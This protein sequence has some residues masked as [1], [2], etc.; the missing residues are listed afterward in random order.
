MREE[1]SRLS[2]SPD[3]QDLDQKPAAGLCDADLLNALMEHLPDNIYFKD[4]SSRFIRINK[5]AAKWFG[6]NHPDDAI[7]KTDF[8]L[9]TQEHAQQAFNDEQ[10]IIRTGK[11][12]LHREEKETWPDGTVTWVDTSKLPLRDRNGNVI[13]TFGI[14]TDITEKKRAEESLRAAKEAAEVAREAAESASRAKSEFVA[15]M[16]HEIRTPMNAIIGMAE[17]LLDTSLSSAQRDYSQTILESGESLLGLLNDVLDFA[18]IE[19]G[20]VELDPMPF[21]IRERIGATMKT[22]AA[23]AHRK[24]LELACRIEA[25]VPE[26]VIGDFGRIRQILLNLIGNA[27]K[28]TDRGE[29]VLE[30]SVVNRTENQA[31]L[32]FDIRDTG[33]GIPP[34]KIGSIFEEFEQ[35]DKSTTRRFGGTGLGLTIA[36]RLVAL[37]GGTIAV[38]SELGSGSTF[39][40]TIPL[41]ISESDAAVARYAGPPS[42]HGLRV[43][44]VDDNATNRR[45]LTETICGWGMHP[46]AV[47]CAS[48]ALNSL[49]RAYQGG[50]PFGLVLSDL[51]M[52]EM[53]GFDLAAAVR[54]QDRFRDL[55]ILIL[56][57]GGYPDDGAR[58]RALDISGYLTKPVKQSELLQAVS[59]AFAPRL[60]AALQEAGAEPTILPLRRLRVLL[61][62]D[63]LVNQKLAIGLLER[64]GHS[65]TVAETGEE[66]VAIWEEGEFDLILMDVQMPRMDGLQATQLIRQREGSD[67]RHIPIVA[68]TAHAMAG[69]REKCLSAGMDDYVAKPVR[70]HQLLQ[71]LAG[72]FPDLQP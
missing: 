42:L 48:D 38:S 29:V 55:R 19:A 17:L 41:G 13:G 18:K 3:G 66:A 40:L 25:C 21:D 52:P 49:D 36:S 44:V 15:N 47:C 33:I 7:N 61:A 62:E 4:R 16:S 50:K 54:G 26:T 23:R 64:M 9:F 5:G 27:I 8:D 45:I 28:F 34:E 6:L 53:D 20:K 30:V 2:D 10:E 72:L 12:M 56:S 63:S 31:Q 1:P 57:S 71:V 39:S 22:L 58:C 67:L 24:S 68:M 37:M 60:E 35:V 14:S 46:E 59:V 43:L 32:R 51:H 65:V 11:P 69:D 70:K